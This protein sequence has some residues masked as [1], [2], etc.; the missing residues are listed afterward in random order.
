MVNGQWRLKR[1]NFTPTTIIDKSCSTCIDYYTPVYLFM[2]VI[3]ILNQIS[4][5][6]II[7]RNDILFN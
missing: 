7:K 6:I 2:V 4:N 1:K 5:K 3:K